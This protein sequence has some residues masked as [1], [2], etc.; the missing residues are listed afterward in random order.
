VTDAQVIVRGVRKVEG[1]AARAPL[2]RAPRQHVG[3]RP[4]DPYW[5][6]RGWTQQATG[7][8][9]GWY[10]AGRVRFEGRVDAKG[11]VFLI[12]IHH[13]PAWLCAHPHWVCF[14]HD[15]DGW[16]AVHFGTPPGDVSSGI[17]KI[18]RI[19]YEALG[20]TVPNTAK[21]IVTQAPPAVVPRPRSRAAVIRS[22]A[23]RET[24]DDTRAS[25]H[26][27]WGW[28]IILILILLLFFS[29]LV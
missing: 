18:E 21:Q 3:P 2:P 6:E 13:P 10:Q 16:Y 19:L 4:G 1:L 28:I 9:T 15:K 26:L 12:L 7:R 14:Q 27:P 23:R 8:F 24:H 11:R 17:M 22:Q 5:R 29:L 25:G 20:T